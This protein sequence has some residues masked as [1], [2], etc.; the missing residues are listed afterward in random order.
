MA[1]AVANPTSRLLRPR[2]RPCADDRS[3]PRLWPGDRVAYLSAQGR[4]GDV[5]WCLVALLTVEQRFEFHD[6]AAN[7]Y[8]A[9]GYDLPSN[10][11]V[12]SNEPQTYDRTN[13]HPPAKVQARLKAET[14]PSQVV[15]RWDAFYASRARDCGVFLACRADFL[16][17][18]HP[19]V[20]RRS[21]IYSV[22]GRIPGTQNPPRV[23]ADEFERLAGYAT[24]VV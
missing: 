11:M 13:R 4:S 6:A 8:A 9:R 18:W 14:E 22:F 20:L 19:R 10:C 17:L 5:G 7:W 16:E 24:R 21:D 15:R 2:Y 3:S 12:P 23:A 1:R